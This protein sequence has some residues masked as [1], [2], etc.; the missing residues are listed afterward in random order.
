MPKEEMFVVEGREKKN[1]GRDASQTGGGCQNSNGKDLRS[2]ANS[3]CSSTYLGRYAHTS[4]Y[5]HSVGR[6]N[7]VHNSLHPII[8]FHPNGT[9]EVPMFAILPVAAERGLTR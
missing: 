7:N 6:T 8:V 9:M 5:A 2:L 4:T 1:R 3:A